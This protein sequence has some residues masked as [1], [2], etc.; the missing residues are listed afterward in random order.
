MYRRHPHVFVGSH[1][2][3]LFFQWDQYIT[4]RSLS[5][6]FPYLV[7][8]ILTHF[9]SYSSLLIEV[10][11]TVEVSQIEFNTICLFFFSLALHLDSWSPSQ[12]FRISTRSQRLTRSGRTS[13]TCSWRWP[14]SP[15]SSSSSS[16]SVSS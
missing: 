10:I 2:I 5:H 16:S 14:S 12:L 15:A 1:K 4:P 3:Q 11:L 9:R 8:V 6:V 13:S 7:E